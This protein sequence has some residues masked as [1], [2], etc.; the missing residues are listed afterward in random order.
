MTCTDALIRLLMLTA[1]FVQ[2]YFYDF[3]LIILFALYV[4]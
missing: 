4:F 1:A 2:L 3:E